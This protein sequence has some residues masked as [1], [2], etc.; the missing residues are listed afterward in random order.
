MLVAARARGKAG[1]FG[2]K[3]RR[4][5]T[6]HDNFGYLTAALVVLLF[7]TALADELGLRLGQLL[8]QLAIVAALAL[9]VWGMNR[10]THWFRTRLGLILASL[11]VILLG[12]WLETAVVWLLILL[13]YLILTSWLAMEQVLRGDSVD[14]NKIVGAVC[15]YLLMGLVWATLYMLIALLEPSAFAGLRPGPWYQGF[16]ELVYFS[17]ITLTTVG[18]GDIVPVSSLA[19]FFAFIEAVVGQFY[20]AILVASLVGIR[21]AD[22]RGNGD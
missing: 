13:G 3:M 1:T 6:E 8:V 10:R 20:L 5:L 4:R 7:G 9:G 22:W 11:V 17:F 21:L 18:Y 12:R 2:G 14:W 15:V 19:R 16:P